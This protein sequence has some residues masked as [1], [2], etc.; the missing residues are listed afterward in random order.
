MITHLWESRPVRRD[1]HRQ[2]KRGPPPHRMKLQ[3]RCPGSHMEKEMPMGDVRSAL[4][5]VLVI[6]TRVVSVQRRQPSLLGV[7]SGE[8]GKK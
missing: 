8:K 1:Q 7:A 4:S 5:I 6:L 3:E 2:Q